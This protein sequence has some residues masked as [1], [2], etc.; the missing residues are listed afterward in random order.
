[1][2]KLDGLKEEI[3]SLRIA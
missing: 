1:V 3:N 2:P